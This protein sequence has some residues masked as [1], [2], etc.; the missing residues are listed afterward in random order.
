MSAAAIREENVFEATINAV[1][2][3]DEFDYATKAKATLE[4]ARIG[5]T[6]PR[7]GAS[8]CGAWTC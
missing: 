4:R 5:R 8:G 2:I 7:I 3:Y 1:I 6:K